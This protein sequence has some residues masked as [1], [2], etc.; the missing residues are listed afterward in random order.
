[1]TTSNKSAS[2]HLPT[3]AESVRNYVRQTDYVHRDWYVNVFRHKSID[4]LPPRY[5]RAMT[6]TCVPMVDPETCRKLGCRSWNLKNP[7]WGVWDMRMVLHCIPERKTCDI[8][9]CHVLHRPFSGEALKAYNT[10]GFYNVRRRLAT[11]WDSRAFDGDG[12]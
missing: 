5:L 2:Q 6:E 9:V 11:P 10:M 7:D 4:E 3:I 12:K 1:M 8:Y